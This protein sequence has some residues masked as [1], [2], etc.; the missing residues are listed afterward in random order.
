MYGTDCWTLWE[1]A[2]VGCFER[3]H[4]F[5]YSMFMCNIQKFIIFANYF[6][7]YFCI[8]AKI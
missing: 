3:N 4:L 2:R 6:Y 5:I 8:D 1:K 7:K